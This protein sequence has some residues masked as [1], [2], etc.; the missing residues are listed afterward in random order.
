MARKT[1][2][3]MASLSLL[4]HQFHYWRTALHRAVYMFLFK[5]CFWALAVRH[6]VTT[7]QIQWDVVDRGR[8]GGERSTPPLGLA[9]SNRVDTALRSAY[10]MAVN[11]RAGRHYGRR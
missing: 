8:E 1:S 7:V 9:V 2:G 3:F 10:R 4:I 11:N 6:R 5:T